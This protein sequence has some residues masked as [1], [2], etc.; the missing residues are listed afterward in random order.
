VRNGVVI[1]I[2]TGS[3]S[4]KLSLFDVAGNCLRENSFKMDIYHPTLEQAEIDLK[5][6]FANI[7]H[8]LKELVTGYEKDVRGIGL[9]VASPTLVLFDHE[10]KPIRRGI[11]YFDNRSIK[12]VDQAMERFGGGN[13]YFARVGNNPS[14]STCVAATINWVRDHEPDVWGKVAKIGFLNS[15]LGVEL[16]GN[17]AVEPTVSSYSGLL[18]IRKAFSW[19]PKF[20]RH[21]QFV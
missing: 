14:P 5:V 18:R 6:L 13:M 11:A 10:Y 20:L 8:S 17:L 9:S 21:H 12:E 4:T 15:Y 7:I 19:E 16:T 2:D 3:S 1:G